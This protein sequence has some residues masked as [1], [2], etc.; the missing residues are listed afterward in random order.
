[1]DTQSFRLIGTT[2]IVTIPIQ[3]ADGQNVVCWETIE[4]VF[5]G[6][7]CVSHGDVPISRHIKHFPDVVLNVALSS[8][9]DHVRVDSAVGV[10][11]TIR[12]S[13][14]TVSGTDARADRPS[15]RSIEDNFVEGLRVSTA[16]AEMPID[17][18]NAHTFSAGS[19]SLPPTLP[20]QAETPSKTP[21]S[22]KQVVKLASKKANE[23]DGRVQQQEL[24][25][26][27]AYMIS[28]QEASDAKQKEICQLQKQALDQ[29]EEMTQLALRHH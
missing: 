25:T 28:L 1:M 22:F 11:R 27:M 5:P 17:D 15:D 2:E 7:K 29:Q 19:S 9:T 20:S 23:S 12:N 14:Q 10:S 26:K 6:V 4:Q 21:L 3:H 24:N 18:I 8:A 16:L 13:A